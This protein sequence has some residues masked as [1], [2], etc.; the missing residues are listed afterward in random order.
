[1]HRISYTVPVYTIDI[2]GTGSCV[3][4]LMT[5]VWTLTVLGVLVRRASRRKS[6]TWSVFLSSIED[7][8]QLISATIDKHAV[9]DKQKKY[10]RP[11]GVNNS[12]RGRSSIDCAVHSPVNVS[13]VLCTVPTSTVNEAILLSNHL[14]HTKT[15]HE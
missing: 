9:D 13:C 7:S 8:C 1:M 11:N 6:P 2:I 5:S 14:R 12:K 10:E 3:C 15:K 4:D